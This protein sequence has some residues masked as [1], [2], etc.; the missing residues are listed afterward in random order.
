MSSR[1]AAGQVGRRRLLDDLLEAPLHRAFALEEMDRAAFAV[2][3]DLHFDMARPLD[4]GLGVDAAVAEIALRLAGGDARGFRRA[5][6]GARTML[7][8]LPPPPAAALISSGKPIV[9]AAARNASRSP[10]GVTEGATGTPCARA[11]SRAEIL[12]PISRIVSG[13]GPMK[14]RPACLTAAAKRAF[15][16]RKP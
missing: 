6:R 11:K 4:I 14:T 2:A 5:P 7:M 1:S 15:S 13:S 16:E 10:V 12:S 9:S 8:P 3:G